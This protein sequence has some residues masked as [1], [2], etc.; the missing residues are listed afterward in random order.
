MERTADAS[1]PAA[2]ATATSD[3]DSDGDS[4]SGPAA[5]RPHFRS[6]AP[7]L[8]ISLCVLLGSSPDP[9]AAADTLDRV[10]ATGRLVYGSDK[11][12]G[13]PYAYPDPGAPRAVTG[14]EVELM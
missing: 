4:D 11:E 7:A 2:T 9:V 3:L 13:G 6:L 10:R 5:P 14:F 8:T 12:G 1:P